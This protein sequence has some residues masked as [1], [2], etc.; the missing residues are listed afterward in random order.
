MV[1]GL[2]GLAACTLDDAEL[3]RYQLRL[4]G[5]DVAE[6][7]ISS[8]AFVDGWSVHFSEVLF[9]IDEVIVRGDPGE[10]LITNGP[11]IYE[12]AQPSQG[13]GHLV[14]DA[15]VEVGHYETLDFR[16]RLG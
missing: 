16:S 5:G 10:V 7:G 11:R 9:A 2:A 6:S 3:G 12:L 1:T 15:M 13:S 14:A 4:Y 8:P